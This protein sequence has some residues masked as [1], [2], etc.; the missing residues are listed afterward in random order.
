[1]NRAS[2]NRNEGSV[3]ILYTVSL[4]F[5]K[6]YRCITP[7]CENGNMLSQDSGHLAKRSQVGLEIIQWGPFTSGIEDDYETQ[8][9]ISDCLI[10]QK[11]SNIALNYH[12]HKVV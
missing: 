5:R 10:K 8:A 6:K 3:E 12:I 7:T 2:Q 4:L 11:F 9:M 1:M